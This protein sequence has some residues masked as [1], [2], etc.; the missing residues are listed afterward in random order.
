MT[1]G[2]LKKRLAE[3]D[4]SLEVVLPGY[5]GGYDV[6]GRIFSE[7]LA[8]DFYFMEHYYGDHTTIE[9]AESHN[10]VFAKR[11]I[12]KKAFVVIE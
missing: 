3:Y 2:E 7:E 5:K 11:P 10:R 8:E 6:L 9:D 1:V 12:K 4:N